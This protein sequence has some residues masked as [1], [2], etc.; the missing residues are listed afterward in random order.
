M[1]NLIIIAFVFFSPLSFAQYQ[2][3]YKYDEY[4]KDWALVKTSS[5]T[6][7]FIDRTGKEVNTG[8]L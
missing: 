8:Y 3:I 7:G 4:N 6:F 5:G 2:K 1:R